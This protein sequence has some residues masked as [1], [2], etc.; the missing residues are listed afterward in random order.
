MCRHLGDSDAFVNVS[1]QHL[2]NQIYAI[3]RERE[4]GDAERMV[5]DFVNVVEGVLLVHKSVEEDAQ[6]PHIL[7]C[8]AIRLAL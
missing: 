7:L 6:R 4:V 2:T 8:A 5:E 1:I 3:F